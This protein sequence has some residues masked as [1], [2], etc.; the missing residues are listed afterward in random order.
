MAVNIRASAGVC[1]FKAFLTTK[2]NSFQA[3]TP[4]PKHPQTPKPL[5]SLSPFSAAGM[6][7]PFDIF[8]SARDPE[9]C[10]KVRIGIGF[11]HSQLGQ[12]IGFRD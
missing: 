4:N 11:Q 8:D 5:T 9:K 7:S 3:N 6:R 10:L 2:T 1:K 12:G